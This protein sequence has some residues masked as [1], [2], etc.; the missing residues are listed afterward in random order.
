MSVLVVRGAVARGSLPFEGNLVVCVRPLATGL[1]DERPEPDLLLVASGAEAAVLAMPPADELAAG[2]SADA[3][4]GAA[5]GEV[6]VALA[7]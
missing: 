3:D 1:T 5:T 4:S 7:T 6:T 2:A